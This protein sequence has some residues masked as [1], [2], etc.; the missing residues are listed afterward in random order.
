[1]KNNYLTRARYK[2]DDTIPPLHHLLVSKIH[3]LKARLTPGF[4]SKT[5]LFY[6]EKPKNFH[7]LY[8][9]CHKLGYKITNDPHS[10][11]D[12]VIYFEDKTKREEDSSLVN[13]SKKYNIINLNC[14]DIS[15]QRVD[16]VFSKVFGYSLLIDP[17]KFSGKC[18]M[19]SD[20][21]AKHDGKIIDCPVKRIPGYTYQKIVNNQ[22]GDEV[23][24]LR[25]PIFAN[26]IPYVYNKYRSVDDRFSN[27]NARVFITETTKTFS[28][29]EIELI[30]VFAQKFGLNYGEIDIL[31]DRDSKKIY[32]VDVNNTPAG[33]PNHIS[34]KGYAYALQKLSNLFI[35]T[36]ITN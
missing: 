35:S 17:E 21:N 31:R 15:K 28:E 20:E 36:F 3:H 19:K 10:N 16:K 6:P 32:I 14:K 18:V 22:Y 34:V 1:M 12:L 33:P 29:K 7:I 13:L 9:I 24:D 30:S 5:I 11:A 8:K 26:T 25:T 27:R 4:K 2:I 23:L